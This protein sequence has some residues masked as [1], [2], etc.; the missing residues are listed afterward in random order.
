MCFEGF[1]HGVLRF[2]PLEFFQY[3][4]QSSVTLRKQHRYSIKSV[5]YAREEGFPAFME[6]KILQ[7]FKD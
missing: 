1:F 4:S 7:D 6:G 5:R 2:P 3:Y